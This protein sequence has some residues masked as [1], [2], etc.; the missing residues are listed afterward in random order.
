MIQ[1]EKNFT[2]FVLAGTL[3]G[4][5]LCT[6]APTFAV[7]SSSG[8]SA[9]FAVQEDNETPQ[10]P[11]GKPDLAESEET[12]VDRKKRMALV[13]AASFAILGAILILFGYFRLNHATRGF[14][15]G[16]LQTLGLFLLVVW[17]GVAAWLAQRFGF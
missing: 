9:G 12:K 14:Y 11:E 10:T 15:A 4:L 5:I 2:W 7:Y 17:L 8:S 3:L 13:G 6:S 1:A 16:R